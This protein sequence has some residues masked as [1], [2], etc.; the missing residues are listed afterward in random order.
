M[1]KSKA[2]QNAVKLD[3][4]REKISMQM[5]TV[6]GSPENTQMNNP[7]N[8]VSFGDQRS[9]FTGVNE[10]PYGDSGLAAPPQMGANVLNPAGRPPSGLQQSF[11]VAGR[12]KNRV[13]YGMQAQPDS[14]GNSPVWDQMETQRLAQPLANVG[15]PTSP[16]GLGSAAMTPGQLPAGLQGSNGPSLMQGQ[17]SIV[18]GSSPTKINKKGKRTA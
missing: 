11:P 6:P 2:Q 13:P 14:S 8:V 1:A 9:S 17:P 4:M 16:M 7:M 12:G 10:F 18:P 5:A 15:L 3:P